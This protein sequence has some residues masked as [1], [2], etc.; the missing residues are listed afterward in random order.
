MKAMSDK[1]KHLQ[2]SLH[3]KNVQLKQLDEQLVRV[4][5]EYLRYCVA[6]ETV[7]M[8]ALAGVNDNKTT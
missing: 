8:K 5:A 2:Q 7:A 1:I 6:V 3:E 4:Q